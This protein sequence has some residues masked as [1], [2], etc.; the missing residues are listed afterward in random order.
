[1]QVSSSLSSMIKFQAKDSRRDL[2]Q[3]NLEG[4]NKLIVKKSLH[5][6]GILIPFDM[7]KGAKCLT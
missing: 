6:L 1:M 3:P 5:H 4:C 2:A 7:L